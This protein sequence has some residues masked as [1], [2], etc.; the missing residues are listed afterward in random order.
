MKLRQLLLFFAGVV[1]TL[2]ITALTSS[3]SSSF[4]RTPAL[5]ILE[6]K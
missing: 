2:T 6:Y 4:A 1:T 5:I 3:L